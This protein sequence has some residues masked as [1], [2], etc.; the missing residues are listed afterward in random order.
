MKLRHAYLAIER[1]GIERGIDSEDYW[2]L[3]HR[4][5]KKLL[6]I[7][8]NSQTRT[9]IKQVKGNIGFEKKAIILLKEGDLK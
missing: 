2:E 3:V 8:Q 9:L 6:S 7:Y 4:K 1:S 5:G